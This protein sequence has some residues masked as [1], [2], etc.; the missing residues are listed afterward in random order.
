MSACFCYVTVGSREEAQSLGHTLVAERLAAGA[1]IL[2]G[3]RS[4][5]WWHGAL[6]Q[7]EE[8][9]VILKT[10]DTLVAALTDRV[11]QLHSYA[12][13]CVVALAVSGGNPDYLR[14]IES[15]TR[16]PATQPD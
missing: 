11:T 13:P 2:D 1:N 9:V 10:R 4:I 14:W 7:A 16:A 3:A 5:Y 6:E 8:T 15:E 12:C